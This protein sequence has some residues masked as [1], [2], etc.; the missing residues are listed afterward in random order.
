MDPQI[1]ILNIALTVI[2]TLNKY[3]LLQCIKTLM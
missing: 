3:N 2:L 1:L